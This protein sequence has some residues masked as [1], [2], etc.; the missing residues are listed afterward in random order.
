MVGTLNVWNNCTLTGES[1]HGYIG[2]C[3]WQADVT[4][5]L[6]VI[7]SNTRVD[8]LTIWCNNLNNVTPIAAPPT[9][10]TATFASYPRITNMLFSNAYVAIGAAVNFA[11][12]NAAIYAENIRGFVHHR[13]VY[14]GVTRDVSYV[15]QLHSQGPIG[16]ASWDSS[17]YSYSNKVLVEIE[18]ADGLIGGDWF[19]FDGR[20]VFKQS[21]TGNLLVSLYNVCAEGV[22]HGIELAAGSQNSQTIQINGGYLQTNQRVDGAYLI[23]NESG[24]KLTIMNFTL[25][26]S[27]N[28]DYVAVQGTGV[29]R[30]IG[31]TVLGSTGAK[32]FHK[33]T[34]TSQLV[35]SDCSIQACSYVLYYEAGCDQQVTFSPDNRVNTGAGIFQNLAPTGFVDVNDPVQYVI[36]GVQQTLIRRRIN[37]SN[38]QTDVLSDFIIH[39]AIAPAVGDGGALISSASNNNGYNAS[40]AKAKMSVWST[41]STPGAERGYAR[42]CGY[43]GGAYGTP[44]EVR[45]DGRLLIMSLAFVGAGSGS[46]EGVITAPVGSI[47]LR[48]DGGVGTTLY[49]KTSGAGNTGW[50]AS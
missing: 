46:P 42:I 23:S 38:H 30:I 18:G 37:S 1:G 17:W 9:I 22:T 25:A 19:S 35:V 8:S 28:C 36:N 26:N 3:L 29:T 10:V 24:D 31:C 45:D 27:G 4:Q 12:D 6:M 50:T 16:G 2:A 43:S 34:A 39:R 13:M 11:T 20:G 41:S 21:G 32:A 14:L 44:L 47:W 48:S 49:K 40:G 5:S 33:T 7:Y 15:R